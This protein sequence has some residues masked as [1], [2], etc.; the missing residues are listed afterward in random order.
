MPK[1]L[2]ILFFMTMGCVLVINISACSV[3]ETGV[4]EQTENTEGRFVQPQTEEEYRKAIALAGQDTESLERVITY[5]Q[6][7]Q[8]MEVLNEEDYLAMSKV[9]ESLGQTQKQREILINVHQLYPSKEYVRMISDIVV[10]RTT[11][12]NDISTMVDGIFSSVENND[13]VNIY[14]IICS[15]EWDKFLQDKYVGVTKKTKFVNE[16][17]AVQVKSDDYETEITYKLTD[18]GITYIYVNQN[19][20]IVANTAIVN[21]AYNGAFTATYYNLE[22]IVE[23]VYSGTF[24]QNVCVNELQIEYAGKTYIGE[25]DTSGKTREEQVEKIT[26]QG[27][28]VYAYDESDESFLYET[29]VQVEDF[30]IDSAYIGIPLYVEW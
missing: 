16:K 1:I 26:E 20:M 9:Y 3:K 11:S 25:F 28:V 29:E 27:G 13:I 12:D 15:E 6:D 4:T 17:Y 30:V 21:G 10:E 24:E 7:L 23:K 2:R 18:D 14:T 19:G 8:A 22:G 5:Y